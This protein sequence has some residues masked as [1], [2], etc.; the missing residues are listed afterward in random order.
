MSAGKLEPSAL[1]AP[2]AS[3]FDAQALES[4]AATL[5][6]LDET[7]VIVWTN[8]AWRAFALEND[9]AEMLTRFGVGARYLDGIAGAL[10][11][12]YEDVFVEAFQ[13]NKIL[14]HDYECSSDTVERQLHLRALPVPGAGLLLEH[15]TVWRAPMERPGEE[16]LETSYR[17][18]DGFVVQC[19][20]CRRVRHRERKRWD[21]VPAWVS[22]SHPSTSHG[23][24]EICLD[25][26][27]VPRMRAR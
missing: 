23:L 17:N 6:A 1:P 7:G 25:L 14:H 24:C 13:K 21:W 18:A 3:R 16:A 20:N 26:Y 10:R 2:F 4:D 9:G 11:S 5:V 19:S 27:L 15:S 12:F 22:D 8:P